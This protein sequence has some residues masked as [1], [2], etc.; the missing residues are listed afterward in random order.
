M[1]ADWVFR[2]LEYRF[3]GYRI[4]D[5]YREPEP[6]CNPVTSTRTQNSRGEHGEFGQ[7]LR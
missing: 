5:Q 7:E 2:F 4:S 6:S 1:L 3:Q